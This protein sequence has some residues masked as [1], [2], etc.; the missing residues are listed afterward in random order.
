MTILVLT[1]SAGTASFMSYRAMPQPAVIIATD[2]CPAGFLKSDF[3][4]RTALKVAGAP[5]AYPGE[6][7]VRKSR[8]SGVIYALSARTI[9]MRKPKDICLLTA[10]LKKSFGSA[11]PGDSFAST[12]IPPIKAAES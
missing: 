11:P 4:S 3:P 7:F 10:F 5:I 9:S 12:K 6:S 2:F 8:H 1:P